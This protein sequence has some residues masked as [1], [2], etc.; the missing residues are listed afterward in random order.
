MRGLLLRY[1]TASDIFMP[2][3]ETK[4]NAEL[5]DAGD[6]LR[7]GRASRARATEE[8]VGGSAMETARRNL[9]KELN[10]LRVD[11]AEALARRFSSDDRARFL[12]MPML[13]QVLKNITVNQEKGYKGNDY[14][15]KVG[16]RYL[17]AILD[18]LMAPGKK[19]GAKAMTAEERTL[20]RYRL[21][22]E[23]VR[24]NRFATEILEK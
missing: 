13:A 19:S 9:V 5:T 20:A 6:M 14:V 22:T 3:K 4:M 16:E 8:R 17:E 11:N 12:Y 21:L 10:R 15:T 23:F 7:G 18:S 1:L 2:G 24:Y